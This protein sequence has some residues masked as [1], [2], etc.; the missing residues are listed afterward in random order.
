MKFTVNS[1]KT[2]RIIYLII[3]IS[4]AGCF[5][6]QSE[7]KNTNREQIIASA[8]TFIQ[9]NQPDKTIEIIENY[10]ALSGTDATLSEIL[11]HAY[12]INNNKKLAG[13]YYEQSANLSDIKSFNYLKAAEEY[14][15]INEL[16]LAK[17]CYEK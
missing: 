9:D 17:V 6:Q 10:I 12:S 13:F 7:Q 3:C 4:I 16:E 11:A 15:Q 14:L 8:N 2:L 5:N 1:C